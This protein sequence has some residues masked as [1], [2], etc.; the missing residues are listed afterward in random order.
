MNSN[1]EE[2]K[3]YMRLHKIP[4]WKVA[5]KLGFSEQTLIR[6]FRHELTDEEKAQYM[7][8]INEI[9]KEQEA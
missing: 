1:T 7:E 5:D 6:R 8:K 3:S 2:I 9:I 4:Y